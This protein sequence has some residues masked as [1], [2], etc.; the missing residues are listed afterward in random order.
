MRAHLSLKVLVVVI[1]CGLTASCD[2]L[3][4]FAE[5]PLEPSKPA[6]VTLDLSGPAT[7]APGETVSFTLVTVS[8]DGTR[9]DVTSTAQW[10]SNNASVTSTQGQGRYRANA[11]GD[12]QVN[13]RFGALNASREVVVVPAGTFRVTGRVVESDGAFPISGARVR[14]PKQL[15]DRTGHGVGRIGILQVVW[16]DGRC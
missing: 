5:N 7:F 11:A 9:R 1:G 8:H 3:K 12:T 14:G 6:L 15:G 10:S 13:A 4:P 16:S 2:D